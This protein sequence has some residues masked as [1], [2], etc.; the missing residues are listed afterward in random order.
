MVGELELLAGF[1][2]LWAQ[3]RQFARGK[4]PPW[5]MEWKW[6]VLQRQK[7]ADSLIRGMGAVQKT[8]R[9][10]FSRRDSKNARSNST[11]S[12]HNSSLSLFTAR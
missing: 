4:A 12:P 3:V 1:G 9:R 10:A 7:A 2:V 6:Q 5:Q 11:R 8:I